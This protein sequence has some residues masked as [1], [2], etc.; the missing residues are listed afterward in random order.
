[1]ELP[2]DVIIYILQYEGR[3]IIK[4][5]KIQNY[6][7]ILKNDPRYDMLLK[8]PKKIYNSRENYY[9]VELLI[10]FDS[11]YNGFKYIK[12][13]SNNNKIV[14]EILINIGSPY[15]IRYIRKDSY[16]IV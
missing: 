5:G 9:Y 4:K 16:Y 7:Q 2:L 1:M 3:F 14:T 11:F 10:E 6:Y 12:L 15:V 8:I 13:S